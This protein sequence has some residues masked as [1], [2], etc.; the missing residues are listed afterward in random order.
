MQTLTTERDVMP[1]V[2]RRL[3]RELGSTQCVSFQYSSAQKVPKKG[4]TL[5]ESYE[6]GLDKLSELYGVDFRKL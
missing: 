4:Y 5:E 6:R 2:G 3:A 1:P